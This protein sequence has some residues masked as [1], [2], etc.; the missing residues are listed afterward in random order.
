MQVCR[1]WRYIVLESAS[2]LRLTLVCTRGTPVADMLVHSPPLPIIID[3]VDQDYD[4]ATEDE[5]GIIHALKHRNRVRR[6]RLRKSVPVLERLVNSLDGEF[7]I[8]E[9]LFVRSQEHV[10]PT[11]KDDM[12]LNLPET[13]RAPQVRHLLLMNFAISIGSPLLTT[14]G[15]LVTL[16]LN[17]IPA[18]A[19]FN[20]NSLLQ[21]LSLTPQLEILG[22]IFNSYYPGGNVGRRPLRTPI[23]ARVTLPNLRWLGF[24]GASGYLEVL[25]SHLTTPLL[26]KLQVY[27][28]NQLTYSI[29]Q[30]QQFMS[31]AGNLRLKT[32]MLSFREDYLNVRAYPHKDAKLY[33]LSMELSGRNLDWE[34]ASAAQVFH[35]L[36]TV[37]SAVEHL[38]LEY[39]RHNISSE[40]NNEA[41]R[42]QWRELFESFGN[43][44]TLFVDG[45]L[46]GQ[47]SRALQPGEEESPSELLPELQVLSY[48]TMDPS[49]NV[50]TL[51]VDAR[52]KAGS[53]ITIVHS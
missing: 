48:P 17:L 5:E 30:L 49:L 27:F 29:P 36:K 23:I 16:S 42:T 2:Y 3:H 50:F 32:I 18:S 12:A 19:Y 24:K 9:Y 13:F 20:P 34:V 33:T 15:N 38:A 6:I 45:E 52:Q 41:D 40:W 39:A 14:M 31:A 37:F 1:R 46:V 10:R 8:L 22:I 7:T 53:P 25:L 51:F 26:E 35:T 21:R 43:V 28:Y 4:L 44:K 47:V 11:I